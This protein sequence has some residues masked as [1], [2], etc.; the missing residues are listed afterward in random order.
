MGDDTVA[1]AKE[2]SRRGNQP[3]YEFRPKPCHESKYCK[4]RGSHPTRI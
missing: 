2:D 3:S 4:V 1:E